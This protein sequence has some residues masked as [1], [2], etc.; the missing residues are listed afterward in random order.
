MVHAGIQDLWFFLVLGRVIG[1]PDPVYG[2][3]FMGQAVQLVD[4]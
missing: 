3:S 1:D 2:P 4:R